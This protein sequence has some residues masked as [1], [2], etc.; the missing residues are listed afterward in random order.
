MGITIIPDEAFPRG[1]GFAY[2]LKPVM[3]D[4]VRD[5]MLRCRVR[6]K[7]LRTPHQT[8]NI[9]LQVLRLP[10]IRPHGLIDFEQA[11]IKYVR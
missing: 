4:V 6:N 8:C 5:I 2:R 3:V 10:E 11:R 9:M 7:M 1:G